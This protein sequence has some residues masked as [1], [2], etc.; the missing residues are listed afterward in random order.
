MA[1]RSGDAST[2]LD[3]R[4]LTTRFVLSQSN[5][6]SAVERVSLRVNRGETLAL[7]GESGSGKSATVMSILRLLPPTGRIVAGSVALEGRNL[8]E[9]GDED[10]RRCRGRLIGLVPQDPFSALNPVLTV[11]RQLFEALRAHNPTISRSSARSRS[12]DALSAT[13]LREPAAQLNRYPHEFSGGMRQR[14]LIAMAIINNPTLLLADEPTTA[15]DTTTQAQ[16]LALLAE[17]VSARDMGMLLITHDIGVVASIA[18]RVAVM[19]SGEIVETG[20]SEAVFAK[21]RHPY[22]RVL[23]AAAPGWRGTAP[24]AGQPHARAEGALRQ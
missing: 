13:G 24:P 20:T 11:G 18:E 22:T 12:V 19:H 5:V 10:M 14:I 4:D 3:V 21:P 1:A 16:I 23:L 9:L 8:L 15:L 17:L 6:V 7:V 2:L